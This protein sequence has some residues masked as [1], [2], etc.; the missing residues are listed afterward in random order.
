MKNFC[1]F[2]NMCG[3]VR[4]KE[5]LLEQ[6]RMHVAVRLLARSDV[7][8]RLEKVTVGTQRALP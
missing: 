1:I 6:N 7:Q 8:G 3:Q 4:V 2:S 5:E